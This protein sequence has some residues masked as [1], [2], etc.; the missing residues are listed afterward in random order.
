[1][2]PRITETTGLGL[3][4]L[5]PADAL[6]RF[7]TGLFRAEQGQLLGD[8]FG[9]HRSAGLTPRETT[10]GIDVEI[11]MTIPCFDCEL[12]SGQVPGRDQCRDFLTTIS[13]QARRNTDP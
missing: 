9:R 6:P 3:S 10:A 7:H 12:E 13:H 2:F 4:R 1:M 8:V 5:D 11:G